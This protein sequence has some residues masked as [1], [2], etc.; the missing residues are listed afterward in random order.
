MWLLGNL[1]DMFPAPCELEFR[2][3][4]PLDPEPWLVI[5]R[6]GSLDSRGQLHRDKTPSQ[7]H[8]FLR[9]RPHSDRDW[10]IAVDVTPSED[11]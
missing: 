9:N 1:G 5:A 6:V 3:A 4:K 7:A 11:G 8:D 10:A 2:F